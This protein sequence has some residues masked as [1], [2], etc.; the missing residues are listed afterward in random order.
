MLFRSLAEFG[1]L[2]EINEVQRLWLQ[3]L[4]R[5]GRLGE[6][7]PMRRAG[8]AGLGEVILGAEPQERE[9][10]MFRRLRAAGLMAAHPSFG[11][12]QAS[13]P[14]D[15]VGAI[16]DRS[17]LADEEVYAALQDNDDPRRCQ[18]RLAMHD[19]VMARP[20]SVPV[21]LLRIL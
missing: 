21:D 6:D 3:A 15:V 10:A 11:E 4:Q 12:L 13:I 2:V 17:G 8:L 16:I 1:E 5:E 14:G 18:V 9:Q 7:C 19:V 20:G